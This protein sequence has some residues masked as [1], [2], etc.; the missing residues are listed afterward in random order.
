VPVAGRAAV[1]R[2]LLARP[3]CL[4]GVS[5]IRLE[6]THIR[7]LRVTLDGRLVRRQT[8]LLLQRTARPLHRFIGPGRHRLS[9][10]VTFDRGSGTAPVTLARTITICGAVAP[11]FTG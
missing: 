2:L 1:A 6:G 4:S 5:Q 7:R 9:V 10:R 8:L 11:R 3:G